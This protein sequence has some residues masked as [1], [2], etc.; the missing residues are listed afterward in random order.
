MN[1]KDSM[2]QGLKNVINIETTINRVM[3][4]LSKLC[5]INYLFSVLLFDLG[6][7]IIE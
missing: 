5:I 7:E 3:R 2:T 4:K 1:Q 6:E